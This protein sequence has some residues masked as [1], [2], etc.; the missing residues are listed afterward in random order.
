M[1]KVLPLPLLHGLSAPSPAK[2]VKYELHKGLLHLVSLHDLMAGVK[3]KVGVAV[4]LLLEQLLALL[5]LV[6]LIGLELASTKIINQG[7][8]E[9][10]EQWV[11]PN[12]QPQQK[13]LV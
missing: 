12:L 5:I 1:A 4:K 10:R 2:L 9:L 3:V 7:L 8:E 11:V 6:T 13:L